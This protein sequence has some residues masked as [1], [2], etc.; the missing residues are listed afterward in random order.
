[1]IIENY[2]AYHGLRLSHNFRMIARGLQRL[3]HHHR[4][5]AKRKR[6]C[7]ERT[8]GDEG[9]GGGGDNGDRMQV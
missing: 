4:C 7:C 5:N 9:G 2:C 3:R 1:M 8:G 6:G